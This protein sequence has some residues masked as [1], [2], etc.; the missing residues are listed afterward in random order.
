MDERIDT[1]NAKIYYCFLVAV[2]DIALNFTGTSHER[3]ISLRIDLPLNKTP[4][5]LPIHLVLAFE[6]FKYCFT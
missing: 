3:N 5:R 6:Y 1:F 2:Q 4:A